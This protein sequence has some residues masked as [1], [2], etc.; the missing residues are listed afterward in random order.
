MAEITMKSK[1]CKYSIIRFL[2]YP[3]TGEF[4]NIG[5]VLYVPTLQGIVYKLVNS[6]QHERITN[7]FKPMNKEVFSKIIPIIRDELERIK[8][9]L[10]QTTHIDSEPYNDLI[11]PREDIIRYS[12]N[13]VIVSTSPEKTVIELFESYVHH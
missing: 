8:K 4:A 11:R 13:R 3:E 9:L 10:T 7:F 1:I 6:N 2:P 12:E 5:I